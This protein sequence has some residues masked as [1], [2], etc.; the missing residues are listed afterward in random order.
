MLADPS[1]LRQAAWKLEITGNGIGSDLELV[2]LGRGVGLT[3]TVPRTWNSAAVA[4]T[5]TARQ[6]RTRH[7]SQPTAAAPGPATAGASTS[8]GKLTGPARI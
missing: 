7:L 4:A 6:P 2:L 5:T 1:A 3:A 8:T